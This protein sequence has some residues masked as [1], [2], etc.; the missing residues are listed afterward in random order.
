MKPLENIRVLDFT[1]VL[2]GPLCT[3]YLGDL[4]ADVLK[5]EPLNTGDA[6]R[7]WPPF[8]EGVSAIF[9]NVNRNKRSLAINLRHSGSR[10]LIKELALGADVVIENFRNGVAQKLGIDYKTLS[11]INPKLVYCTIKGYGDTGPLKDEPGY[12]LVLQAFSGIMNMTGSAESGPVRIPISPIDQGTGLHAISGILAALL[13]RGSTGQGSKVQVSLFETA[14]GFL[15]FNLERF[16]QTGKLPRRFGSAHESLCPYQVFNALDAPILIGI[17]TNK[18]WAEFCALVGRTEL[19]DD[20]RFSTNPERVRN[21]EATVAITQDIVQQK[22]R[23]EWLSLLRGIGVPCSPV[24]TI[25]EVLDEPQTDARGMIVRY[26]HPALGDIKAI[27]YP[28]QFDDERRV[29]ERAPP[30]LGQHTAE[31]LREMGIP[32]DRIFA[33]AND[34]VVGLGSSGAGNSSS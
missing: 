2:A 6:T 22:S 10:A 8:R 12:D 34:G 17:A 7:Q 1:Q 13:K 30:Q 18:A 29:V 33:L 26:E 23:A 25:A 19:I 32:E 16:W 14:V 3:Q 20:P 15:G 28:I 27:A 31:V 5:I 24:N 9:L 21:F 4:G 11:A